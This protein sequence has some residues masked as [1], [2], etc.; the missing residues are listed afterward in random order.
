MPTL[1]AMIRPLPTDAVTTSVLVTGPASARTT[2]TVALPVGSSL[3]RPPTQLD[4]ASAD[5]CTSALTT[6]VSSLESPFSPAMVATVSESRLP[7]LPAPSAVEVIFRR[8]SASALAWNSVSTTSNGSPAEG[9]T[10]LLM[11]TTCTG[12][13]GP[14][15]LIGRPC[16]SRRARILPYAPPA[17]TM[18][19]TLSVPRCMSV[20][21]TTPRPCST[22]A[23]RTVPEAGR[24]GLA[25]RSMIS[26][27]KASFSSKSSRPSFVIAD[28]LAH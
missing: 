14:A 1:K 15:S 28:T 23:S 12:S 25:L 26:A 18:S 22:E 4:T 13:D 24:S 7:N 16:Q 17:T 3:N 11:P 9:R 20:V 2:L 19:P 27:E 21:A 10:S 8:T 5:P 6:T